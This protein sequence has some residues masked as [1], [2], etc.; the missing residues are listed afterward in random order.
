MEC[1]YLNKEL[2]LPP[3]PPPSWTHMGHLSL[4]YLCLWAAKLLG[5]L[6]W[7][8]CQWQDLC[9]ANLHS[10]SLSHH[11]AM[12]SDAQWSLYGFQTPQGQPSC[13]Q[14]HCLGCPISRMPSP[15][16]T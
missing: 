12:T 8:D 4:M 6:E 2:T 9:D 7:H 3:P 14:P 15:S 11:C 10:F 16:F 1:D 5:E 13:H